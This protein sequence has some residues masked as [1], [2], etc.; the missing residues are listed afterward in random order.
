MGQFL[1]DGENGLQ[2]TQFA[3]VHANP[4]ARYWHFLIPNH[5]NMMEKCDIMNLIERVNQGLPW[6]VLRLI[7]LSMIIIEKNN[8]KNGMKYVGFS[9]DEGGEQSPFSF[10]IFTHLS[11]RMCINRTWKFLSHFCCW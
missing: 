1:Q 4:F 7:I 11:V 5:T 10:S 3:K 2:Q 6:R 9:S 8:K